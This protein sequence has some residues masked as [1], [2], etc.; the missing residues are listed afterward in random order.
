MI[1]TEALGLDPG[2]AGAVAVLREAGVETFESC[3]GGH[4]H[5]YPGLGA[6]PVKSSYVDGPPS[7]KGG[8]A[9]R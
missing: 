1:V 3:E 5:A 2:I 9:A 8:E 6:A 7:R 4:G